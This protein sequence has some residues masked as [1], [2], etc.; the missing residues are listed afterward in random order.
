MSRTKRAHSKVPQRNFVAK[1]AQETGAGRHTDQK[2][3]YRRKPK[4]RNQ[5]LEVLNEKD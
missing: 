1:N 3:D 4:H 2:N 5:H